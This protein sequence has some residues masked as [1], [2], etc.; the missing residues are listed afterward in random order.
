MAEPHTV[1]PHKPGAFPPVSFRSF[2]EAIAHTKT[3]SDQKQ[4]GSIWVC[5]A[6]S[7]IPPKRQQ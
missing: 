4:A 3:L 7:F 6:R 2:G 1:Y 5:P